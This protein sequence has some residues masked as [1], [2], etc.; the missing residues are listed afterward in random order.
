MT[1]ETRE[2]TEQTPSACQG[3]GFPIELQPHPD[4]VNGRKSV[5]LSL[6]SPDPYN[7]HRPNSPDTS[8]AFPPLGFPLPPATPAAARS[9]APASKV[10]PQALQAGRGALIYRLRKDAVVSS[11]R[12]SAGMSASGKV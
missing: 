12:R 5:A 10:M 8:R 6:A 7:K 4:K 2:D 1:E 11:S 9:I 3:E